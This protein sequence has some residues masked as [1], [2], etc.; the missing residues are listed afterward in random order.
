LTDEDA[1]GMHFEATADIQAS[2]VT[3]L[4]ARAEAG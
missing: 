1:R 4:K 2:P 3:G